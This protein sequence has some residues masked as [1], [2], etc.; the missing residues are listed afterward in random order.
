MC[1]KA[2]L[3][4]RATEVQREKQYGN[5][6]V[7]TR[8]ER[9]KS[10]ERTTKTI[11]ARSKYVSVIIPVYNEEENIPLLHERVR[12]VMEQQ[13]FSYEIIYVDDGS[14]DATF[15]HLQHLVKIDEHVQVVRFRRN[16]GQ[17]AAIAAG[18][19]NSSGEILVFM[20]GDLQNDPI[21]IPRL[22]AKL[23]EGYDVVS[24]WRKDRQDAQLSRKLPS[25]LANKLISQVT[26]V[27]LHDYGCTL[28]AYRYEVFRHIR[29]YG[30]MHRF[31]PAYAALAGASIAEIPVT[32]HA[33]QFGKSKYGISR[34]VRVLLDLMTLKFLGSFGTKPLYAFGMLGLIGLV[35]GGG[36]SGIAVGQRVLPPYV[37]VHRNP[38][39]PIALLFSGFGILSMM[40]GLLAELLTRTYHEAQDK[41]T[42]V[43]KHILPHTGTEP[44]PE[45]TFPHLDVSP[46]ARIEEVGEVVGKN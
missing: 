1:R 26:G 20:D 2:V 7:L 3:A 44:L 22:L 38:L 6:R 31:I 28:K 8:F 29:L 33:R 35:L 32:H 36:V 42:Y 45:V 30:E 39:L 21:D 25:L 5:Q 46:S 11:P 18:V 41:P 9:Q 43:V 23:D 13:S 40:I 10:V 16:F 17:T 14:K 24:G 19:A 27:H 34:V 12:S 37:R 15:S 4:C